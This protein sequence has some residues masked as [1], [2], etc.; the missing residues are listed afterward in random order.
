MHVHLQDYKTNCATDIVNAARTQG[1]CRM[2]CAASHE[3]DWPRVGELA[4]RYPQAV[5][6]AF[7]IHPWYAAAVRS[8]WEE[9]LY[10][11]LEQFPQALI[12]E[13]GLDGLKENMT[14]QRQ[15]FERQIEAALTLKRPLVVHAVKAV[16]QLQDFW[17]RMPDFF[18]IHSFNGRVEHLQPILRRN[19]YVSLSAS[20]LHNRQ[21]AE[22]ARAV[23]ASRLLLET[24]S[25]YQGPVKGE[26]QTPCFL[27][28]ILKQV[29]VWRQ[30]DP[31]QLAEVVYANAEEFVNGK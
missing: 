29:A 7:G 5:I 30:Q 16:A 3:A 28:Q 11:Q 9:R 21:G 4:S 8:G 2:V 17:S 20:I 1:I 23:P 15:L 27:P 22:I 10:K 26:E 25:P 24:D 14:L 13:S 18:M 31:Q 6:P 19:G 12:G